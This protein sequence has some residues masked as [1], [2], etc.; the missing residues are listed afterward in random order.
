VCMRYHVSVSVSTGLDDYN[1]VRYGYTDILAK[2][3]LPNIAGIIG[4]SGPNGVN[5]SSADSCF[6]VV[7]VAQTSPAPPPEVSV[8][9]PTCA[10][11]LLAGWAAEPGTPPNTWTTQP[12]SVEVY[13]NGPAGGGGVLI[14][15][16]S[17]S[18]NT[19]G[20]YGF[21]STWSLAIPSA[22]DTSGTTFW[23]Y[24]INSQGIESGPNINGPALND[25]IQLN[26]TGCMQYTFVPSASVD[27]LSVGPGGSVADEQDPNAVTFTGSPGLSGG[28]G[29]AACINGITVQ[30]RTYLVNATTG[31]VTYFAG[32]PN[33][34]PNAFVTDT[35][36]T[37]VCTNDQY[38][39]TPETINDTTLQAGDQ[40][41]LDLK[42]SPSPVWVN[43]A[44][45]IIPP[46]GVPVD[47]HECTPV[48]NEPFFK[49]FNSSISSGGEFNTVPAA[50][51]SKQGV[52]GAWYYYETAYYG[53]HRN[54]EY[55]SSSQLGAQALGPIVGFGTAQGDEFGT[56]AIPYGLSFA[57][58]S[59]DVKV[60]P[61]SPDLGGNLGGQ[62][63]I[64]DAPSAP[65][66]TTSDIGNSV[67]VG[68]GA[69][70]NGAHS[71]SSGDLTING[72]SVAAGNN[73]AIYVTGHDVYIS[74]P[75]TYGAW[76][77]TSDV[78]SFVLVVTDG[79]IYINPS[80]TEL[81]GI[82][83]AKAGT[84]ADTDGKIYDCSDTPDGQFFKAM[85]TDELYDNCNQQLTVYGSFI[86]DQV[87]LM[88]TFGSLRD[89]ADSL[90]DQN[91]IYGPTINCPSTGGSA[92][93][94][95]C[96]AEVFDFSPEMY[97]SNPAIALPSN[98]A[99]KYDAITSLPPVL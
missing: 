33:G 29:G 92:L 8:N 96:A 77:S 26:M 14:G 25:P 69:L 20:V 47:G 67:T 9:T 87:N 19:H 12:V 72:G 38:Q 82:Y 48:D 46:P 57:N 41:C 71:Y 30:Y 21:G 88:R 91:P 62:H 34:S 2:N 58:S 61:D 63:C 66:N 31:A 45:Q 16:T 23:V 15:T 59:G 90:S 79:N 54:D 93:Y 43:S 36:H 50:D 17:S 44:G 84:S 85:P 35:A 94:S 1:N 11:S 83:V 89:T 99:I 98:G 75:I 60:D 52:L 97:L 4:R 70:V 56:G 73:V 27:L 64:T 42:V 80:V 28:A 78:P 55:G 22:Y 51:C 81:D 3:D 65:D 7:P 37:R 68:S 10:Q 49:V 74:N 95:T 53:N 86:A 39:Y 76:A 13:A 32:G 6:S 24:A 5:G 18:G 40:Y